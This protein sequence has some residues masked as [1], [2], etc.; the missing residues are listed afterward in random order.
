MGIATPFC[1]MARNDRNLLQLFPLTDR[2][3]VAAV[4]F[5]IGGMALYPVVVDF[6]LHGKGKQNLPQIGIQGRLLVGLDPAL[7]L[8]APGPALFQSIDDLLGVGIELH[9][10]GLFQC[11]QTFDHGGQLH[12]VVGW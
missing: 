12:P 10:A 8:P 2:Q 5:G 3:L 7:L 4:V 11:L 1:G 9:V 6:M